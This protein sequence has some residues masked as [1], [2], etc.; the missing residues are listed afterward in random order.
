MLSG[1]TNSCQLFFF[2]TNN[3]DNL[4]FRIMT[5]SVYYSSHLPCFQNHTTAN[6]FHHQEYPLLNVIT[7]MN[8]I[9][10]QNITFSSNSSYTFIQRIHIYLLNRVVRTI[11]YHSDIFFSLRFL[12]IN[13]KLRCSYNSRKK[14]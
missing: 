13:K 6:L 14:V 2:Q 12:L 10:F 7:S 8:S 11:K 1:L 9:T 3:A 5:K 4:I